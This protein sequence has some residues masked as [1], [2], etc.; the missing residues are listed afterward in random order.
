LGRRRPAHEPCDEGLERT[1]A[2]F[3]SVH[4]KR[5]SEGEHQRYQTSG[6]LPSNDCR[7]AAF[8]LTHHPGNQT[9]Q[10]LM[11][12]MPHQYLAAR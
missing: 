9:C 6:R 11:D 12:A 4:L 3:D 5:V 2:T 7:I 1:S 8:P 10:L